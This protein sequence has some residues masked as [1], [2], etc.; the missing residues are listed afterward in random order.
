MEDLCGK[1]WQFELKISEK[2]VL[3]VPLFSGKKSEFLLWWTR[4]QAYANVMDCSEALSETKMKASLPGNEDEVL[5]SSVTGDVPKMAAKKKNA[6]AMAAFTLTFDSAQMMKV[7]YKAKTDEWPSGLAYLV[8]DG[9]MKKFMP[10]DKLTN[11]EAAKLLRRV[12]MKPKDDPATLFEQISE[13]EMMCNG[14]KKKLDEDVLMATV[15]DA[16][17]IG[18]AD[19]IART[20]NK[21]GDALTMDQLEEAFA[22]HFRIMD[23]K[24]TNKNEE[25]D[26]EMAL[27]I[28]DGH[29]KFDGKCNLCGKH[30]H[31]A[32]VCW[33]DPKNADKRPTWWK[34]SEVAGVGASFRKS[35]ELQL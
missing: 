3:K 27:T 1:S 35:N 16:A 11:V 29:K 14:N 12:S 6:R 24:W 13:I 2:S 17:P 15:M 32:V 9:L 22:D 7:V 19:V 30:G 34:A 21:H 23:N 8:V 10:K 31:K 4:F 20:V 18:Y 25:E 33:N 28:Q 26:D 5:S